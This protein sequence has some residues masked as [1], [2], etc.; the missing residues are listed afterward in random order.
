[1][2]VYMFLVAVPTRYASERSCILECNVTC[3]LRPIT[4]T[5]SLMRY[6]RGSGRVD[7]F[8]YTTGRVGSGHLHNGSG[9]VQKKVTRG[10]LGRTRAV[11]RCQR[12]K[13]AEH[14]PVNG[15]LI[16]TGIRELRNCSVLVIM[17]ILGYVI[18]TGLH[19]PQRQG[20]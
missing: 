3:N 16:H 20:A 17:F 9:R 10:Q 18:Y 5:A 15:I 7:N 1:M 2:F 19:V 4:T 11:S 8:V 6:K 13:G 14:R 12:T